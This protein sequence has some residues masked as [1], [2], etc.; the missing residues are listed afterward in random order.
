MAGQCCVISLWYCEIQG[1]VGN[2]G[3][4]GEMGYQGDKVSLKNWLFHVLFVA[5]N[6]ESEIFWLEWKKA[7]ANGTNKKCAWCTVCLYFSGCCWFA[8]SCWANRTSRTAGTFM[9]TRTDV[10]VSICALVSAGK[11]IFA[12]DFTLTAHQQY[13]IPSQLLNTPWSTCDVIKQAREI[14]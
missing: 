12:F 8:W 10:K 1:E 5:V 13:W 2:R 14:I 7:R 4:P 9:Q 3:E 11:C 6:L